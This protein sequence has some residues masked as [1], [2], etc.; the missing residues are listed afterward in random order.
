MAFM[1]TICFEIA[2][3]D[4]HFCDM[5][6]RS[7]PKLMAEGRGCAA[8]AGAGAAAG[9]GPVPAPAAAAAAAWASAC[10]AAACFSFLRSLPR[11][12]VKYSRISDALSRLMNTQA[13]LQTQQIFARAQGPE[14]GS[15][16]CVASCSRS[17]P[18]GVSLLMA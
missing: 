1:R 8:T 5:P 10:F 18:V 13:S 9:A 2:P 15:H 3:R 11:F 16:V 6:P 12:R 4:E 7:Q 14:L 17:V